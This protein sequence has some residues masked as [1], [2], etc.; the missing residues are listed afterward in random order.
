MI[1]S[2]PKTGWALPVLALVTII[3]W[4]QG[5]NKG[6]ATTSSGSN[7]SEVQPHLQASF[8]GLEQQQQQQILPPT[9]RVSTTA[10]DDDA[11]TSLR[12]Q[13]QVQHLVQKYDAPPAR[14]PHDENPLR[15]SRQ[16]KRGYESMITQLAKPLQCVNNSR[17]RG[18]NVRGFSVEERLEEALSRRGEWESNIEKAIEYCGNGR[19]MMSANEFAVIYHLLR[20]GDLMLEWGAG[21]SS[22]PFAYKVGELHSVDDSSTWVTIFRTKMTLLENQ[23]LHWMPSFEAAGKKLRFAIARSLPPKKR[24]N[25]V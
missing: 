5:Y 16:A 20:E 17:W 22:C 6:L 7:H 25:C 13:D 9:T 1:G 19:P 23:I 4:V 15:A 21:R 12:K 24:T 10:N 11:E 8:S 14:S 18:P 3:L 2:R